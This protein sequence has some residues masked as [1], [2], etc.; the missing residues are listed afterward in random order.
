MAHSR[1]RC[2]NVLDRRGI[3]TPHQK[4]RIGAKIAPYTGYEKTLKVAYLLDF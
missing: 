4:P 3:V 1:G 2:H